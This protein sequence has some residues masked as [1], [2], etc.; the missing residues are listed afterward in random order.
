MEK[1]H[2]SLLEWDQKVAPM[3]AVIL[4]RAEKIKSSALLIQE[5]VNRIP[6]APDFETR[7]MQSLREALTTLDEAT[8]LIE[9]TL[10]AYDQKEKVT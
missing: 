6:A 8:V 4:G 7:A 10:D 1:R 3:L 5:W 2:M 9:R